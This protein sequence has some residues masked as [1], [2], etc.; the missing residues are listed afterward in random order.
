MF[1]YVLF[2]MPSCFRWGCCVRVTDA[3]LRISHQERP[4]ALRARVAALSAEVVDLRARLGQNPRE[5]TEAPVEIR[6]ES[7]RCAG[8]GRRAVRR[9][10]RR[11][12]R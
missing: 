4:D 10:A 6:H 3:R 5:L 2:P 7:S 9:T 8:C 11:V 12:P 1:G